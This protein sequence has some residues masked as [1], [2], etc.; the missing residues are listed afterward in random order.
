MALVLAAYT[1]IVRGANINAI[2]AGPS[3]PAQGSLAGGTYI[4]IFGDGFA[5]N[6]LSGQA[7]V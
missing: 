3:G 1:A 6:G 5:M 2:Q 4:T 7:A